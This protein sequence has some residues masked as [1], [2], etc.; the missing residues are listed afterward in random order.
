MCTRYDSLI[1]LVMILVAK[2]PE[3]LGVGYIS[4][5]RPSVGQLASIVNLGFLCHPV[6]LP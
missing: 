3:L 1:L 2:Q 4:S 6:F 5:C